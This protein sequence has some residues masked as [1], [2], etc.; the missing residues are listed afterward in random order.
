MRAFKI[1]QS[2]FTPIRLCDVYKSL[3]CSIVFSKSLFYMSSETLT[4]VRPINEQREAMKPIA[5]HFRVRT[6]IDLSIV[7]RRAE[8]GSSHCA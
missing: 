5:R 8:M 1:V 6:A 2:L 3:E 4:T 7:K